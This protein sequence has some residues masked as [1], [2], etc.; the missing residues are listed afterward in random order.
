MLLRVSEQ[1]NIV[2]KIKKI[3]KASWIG[4]VLRTICLIKDILQGKTEGRIEVTGRRVIRRKQL[5]NGLQ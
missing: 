3:R 1:R 2:H 5:P 4:H